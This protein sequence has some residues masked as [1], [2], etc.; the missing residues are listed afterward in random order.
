MTRPW[1]AL[2]LF[3]ALIPVSSATSPAQQAD[4]DSEHDD[5][6]GLADLAAYRTALSGRAT[7][8]DARPSDPP[9]LVGFRDLWERPEAYRGRRVTVVGRLER[10]FRQGAV[11][12]FPPLV[13][14]W[15]FSAGGDPFCVVYPA[16]EPTADGVTAAGSADGPTNNRA[17]PR[18][19]IMRPD[20]PKAGQMVRFTGTFLKT[21]RYAAR[22]GERLAPLIVGDQPP[23]RQPAGESQ[24]PSVAPSNLKGEIVGSVPRGGHNSGPDNA[25][26]SAPTGSWALAFVLAAMAAAVL[27]WQHVRGTR[28]RHRGAGNRRIADG[29]RPDPPLQFLDSPNDG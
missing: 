4:A 20:V 23:H 29:D 16:P 17:R 28:L 12:S 6:I 21:V 19:P 24:G 27:A 11:G 10:T 26:R 1:I 7:A 2:M 15:L 25:R 8:D 18:T 13:E 9:V 3:V 14:S 5:R 22:N